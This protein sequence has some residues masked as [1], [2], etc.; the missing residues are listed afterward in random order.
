MGYW[1][2]IGVY[3][4]ETTTYSA[5][6]GTNGASPYTPT[7]DG[8][9]KILR[10]MESSQ[11]VTTVMT[12]AQFKLTCDLWKPNSI[13]VGALGSGLHTAPR[14]KPTVIDWLVNLP[15]KSGVPVTLEG[16]ISSAYTNVTTEWAL[17][18]YIE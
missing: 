14:G 17:Y 9:I 8:T 18:A 10:A 7:S 1:K 4:A 12:H 15:I 6:A 2:L 11:A 5:F 16:R 3:D 13:E